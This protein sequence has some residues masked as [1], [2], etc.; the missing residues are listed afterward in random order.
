MLRELVI[1]V[2]NMTTPGGKKTPGMMLTWAKTV[3]GVIDIGYV[4][5]SAFF[6]YMP[7]Q[8]E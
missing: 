8:P 4:E 6:F 5:L 2:V 1:C 3:H 7:D